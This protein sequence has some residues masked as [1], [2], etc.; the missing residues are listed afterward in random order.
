MLERECEITG[1]SPRQMEV[2]MLLMT[3]AENSDIAKF[4]VPPTSERAVKSILH[5]LFL[6]FNLKGS[7]SCQKRVQLAL[8]IHR[9]LRDGKPSLVQ[10]KSMSL[11]QFGLES[12][13]A[14]ISKACDILCKEFTKNLDSIIE[15]NLLCGMKSIESRMA[16]LE[17]RIEE[18]ERE[19]Y[20]RNSA[21][22]RSELS[23]RTGG[24]RLT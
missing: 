17:R 3:G 18:L 12:I 15:S 4:L 6:R 2:A 19:R 11:T 10:G 13:Q 23:S 5:L 22:V 21:T 1:L 14:K 7:H 24:V 20:E 9:L 8:V 16:L